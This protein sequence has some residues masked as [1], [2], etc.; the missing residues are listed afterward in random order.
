[1]PGSATTIVEVRRT[2]RGQ[3]LRNTAGSMRRNAAQFAPI[4]TEAEIPEAF[5]CA[6]GRKQTSLV[7]RSS[8][9]TLVTGH[10][11]AGGS[12]ARTPPGRAMNRAAINQFP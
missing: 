9:A 4:S 7:L 1:M 5:R 8:P 10:P 2:D 12:D 11:R 6:S 3:A